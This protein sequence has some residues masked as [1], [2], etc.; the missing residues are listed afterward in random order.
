[1]PVLRSHVDDFTLFRLA[2]GDVTDDERVGT[3]SH[4]EAC[5]TCQV[6]FAEIKEVNQG[7]K[8]LASEGL[9]ADFEE[10]DLP[11]GDPFKR[12]P[13]LVEGKRPR[14]V[15]IPLEAIRLGSAAIALRR[16]LLGSV[17]DGNIAT[18]VTSLDLRE[19]VQRLALLH[20][21]QES[22]RQITMGPLRASEFAAAAIRRLRL[23]PRSG[24]RS[25]L[26][27]TVAPWALLWGQAHLLA[28]QAGLWT[29][30]FERTARF[31]RIA[32]RAFGSIGDEAS[33]AHAELVEAQRR[34]FVSEG[35]GALILSARARATFERYGLEDLAAVAMAAEGIAQFDVGN[36]EA[37][38]LAFRK[39]LPVFDRHGIWNAYISA[40]NCLGT[41]LTSLGRLD[42]ARRE[43]AMALRRF[44]LAEHK[45]LQGYLRL[46][47]AQIVLSA[48]RY[49]AAAL[50]AAAA[51]RLFS[52]SGMHVN[53]LIATLLEIESWARHGDVARARRRLDRLTAITS[54]GS[55]IDRALK[56]QLSD[57]LSGANP[58]FNQLQQLR[59][60]LKY[61]LVTVSSAR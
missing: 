61:E 57:A 1:M 5:G 37:S 11:D 36:S 48:G 20:A 45:A 27:N 15:R 23:L 50:S 43:Y 6:A 56:R 44:T 35:K 30:E 53:A 46:G 40:L 10:N 33:L 17:A 49:H 28:G 32:Y 7:L 19:P 2:V 52:A 42:E 25:D 21:L 14:R 34:S 4:L 22:G 38:V 60:Q 18:A 41:A 31:L 16:R 55:G 9:L 12:R 8:R 3:T 29:K 13:R 26:A 59:A 51:S 47:L 39:A 58:D 24:V 54:S